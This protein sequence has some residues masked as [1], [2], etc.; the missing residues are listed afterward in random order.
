M[1]TEVGNKG[2]A[3]ADVRNVGVHMEMSK[4]KAHTLRS[5]PKV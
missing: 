3:H 1:H 2:Y 4:T 5:E